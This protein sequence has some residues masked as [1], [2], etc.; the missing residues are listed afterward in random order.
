LDFNNLQLKKTTP[1][2]HQHQKSKSQ[3]QRELLERKGIKV[4]T[5][6]EI[7]EARNKLFEKNKKENKNN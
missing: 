5:L 6:L 1:N 4:P 2:Q 3:K 7:Q